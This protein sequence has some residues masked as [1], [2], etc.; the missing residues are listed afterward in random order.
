MES[1]KPRKRSLPLPYQLYQGDCLEVMA[2]LP[3]GSVGMVLT[4]PPYGTTACKWDAVIPFAPMWAQIKRVIKK[5]GAIVMTASQPFTS[6][7]VVSNVGMFKY[8][9]IWR[10]SKICHFAQAPYRFL[11]EHE[12]V[13]VFSAGG[14]SKNSLNRMTYNPQG[15]KSCNKLCRG[16]GHSEH[17]PSKNKQADYV[18]TTT[19]YP[20][21]ILEF[22]SD[23]AKAHPTQK[24]AALM[25][26]LIR[27]YTSEGQTV[28]D[29]TM[30]SGTTGVAAM[31]TGRKF[32]GIE[33][34]QEYFRIAKERIE[35]AYRNRSM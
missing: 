11:T 4:D 23:P 12:D 33:L 27:T 6:A 9:L 18:Q 13:L 21:S 16:K 35:T 3:D 26:Y 2:M 22:A 19:G 10:K 32:I 28:L 30:G 7:L 31:N 25:E 24:P 14:T 17:R 1:I 8:S 5:N 15:T 29:F 34:D 20:K